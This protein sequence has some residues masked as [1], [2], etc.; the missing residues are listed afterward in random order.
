MSDE[1]RNTEVIGRLAERWNAGD[2]EGVFDLYAD[3]I[4]LETAP[5]WPE[6]GP[7]V[8][9]AAVIRFS[10]DWRSAWETIHIDVDCHRGHRRPTSS[11]AAPGT[12][13]ARSADSTAGS[14]SGSCSR[15]RTD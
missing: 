11:P 12:R 3:H 13:A 8:G 2:L 6:Q 5:E 9:K 14:R 10:A 1:Q 15:S 4:V 7:V